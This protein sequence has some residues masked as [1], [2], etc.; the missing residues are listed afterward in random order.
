MYFLEAST[1]T[2]NADV[3]KSTQSDENIT[4]LWHMRLGH[5]SAQGMKE[6]CKK[7]LLNGM[8][9]SNQEFC[10]NCLYGKHVHFSC[11]VG[12]H[13]SIGIFIMFI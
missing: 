12:Q 10:E 7:G 1:I 3:V 6:L 9:S 4:K 11:S 8:N 5:M 2:G 13:K